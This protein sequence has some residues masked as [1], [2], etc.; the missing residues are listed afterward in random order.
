MIHHPHRRIQER[1]VPKPAKSTNARGSS[2]TGAQFSLPLRP[3]AE[4]HLDISTLEQWLWDAACEIRGATDA[5]KFKD[6]ILPLVFFKRLSDVFDDEFA[7]YVTQYGSEEVARAIIEADHADAL[8]TG[9]KPIVRF[10]IAETYTWRAVRHHRADG[11]LGEFV[12]DAFRFSKG[13]PPDSSA[14]W[15]WV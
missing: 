7:A 14:D 11:R 13:V 1:T 15:G 10:Y 9:R 12:T 3:N 4:E 6:F 2:E 5:P 8:A